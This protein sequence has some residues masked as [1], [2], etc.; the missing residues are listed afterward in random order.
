MAPR[1]ETSPTTA[2]ILRLRRLAERD[3]RRR[4]GAAAAALEREREREA[5]AR[6]RLQQAEEGLRRRP[7]P[8]AGGLRG[9]PAQRLHQRLALIAAGQAEVGRLARDLGEIAGRVARLGQEVEAAQG[10]LRMAV[11]RREAAQ[12]HEA[13]EHRRRARRLAHRAE[14]F[15]E[16]LALVIGARAR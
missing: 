13:L 1:G 5:E 12:L 4:L 9:V 2:I 14:A 6:R 15:E 7:G 10:L 11:A 16:E 8:D 3:L